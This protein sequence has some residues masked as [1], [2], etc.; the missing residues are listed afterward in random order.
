MKLFLYQNIVADHNEHFEWLVN[1]KI[2]EENTNNI[3]DGIIV[4]S[5]TS[6][7]I[8]EIRGKERDD[9]DLGTI[10]SGSTSA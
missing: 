6:F 9:D 5:I 10:N 3:Y 8:L 7:Y 2:M 4:M 1:G